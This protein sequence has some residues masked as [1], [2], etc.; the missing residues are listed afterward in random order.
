[1]AIVTSFRFTKNCGAICVDQESWHVWRRKN[2]FTDHLYS[3]IDPDQATRF[4]VELVYGGVGHPPYHLEVAEKARK[5]L[6]E[7]LSRKDLDPAAVTAEKLGHVVLKAFQQVHRRRVDDKMEYL[8]GFNSDELNAGTF[9]NCQGTFPIQREEVKS[10]ALKIVHGEED[11]GYGPLTPPVEACLIGIDRHYG[12]SAFCLKEK[13]GVLGFQ[14]CWF[15]SLGQ[16]R[17]GPA[18]RFAKLLNQRF[19]DSRRQGIG[20][21]RGVFYLLDAIS[22]AMDHYGQDG[23]FVRMMIIDGDAESAT[24]RLRDIRDNA[25]RLCVEIVKAQRNELLDRETAVDLMT[26][27]TRPEPDIDAVES[28]FFKAVD[29]PMRLGKLLRRYKIEEPG[30][31]EQGPEPR[32]FQAD[33]VQTGAVREGDAS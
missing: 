3:L 26:D 6:R 14:S 32:L 10:R 7:H 8:F 25:A 30:L 15:E 21:D 29:D 4:G 24:D 16:G 11:T 5:L 23:G 12:F 31:P 27:L 19:L 22:E 9:T 33:A 2:W 20:R 13:D 18:I 17:Q 1:M 28:R